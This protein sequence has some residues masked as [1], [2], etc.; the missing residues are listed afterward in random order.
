MLP[1]P[2][3]ISGEI[4]PAGSHPAS[5]KLAIG[6]G[7]KYARHAHSF[8]HLLDEMPVSVHK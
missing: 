4:P 7:G 8:D 1:I 6:D 3:Q 2:S 5:A